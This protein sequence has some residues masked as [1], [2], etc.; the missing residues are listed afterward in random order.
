MNRHLPSIVLDSIFKLIADTEADQNDVRNPA[1]PD[2]YNFSLVNRCWNDEATRRLYRKI[3]VDARFL[4]CFALTDGTSL[5]TV[6]AM[7]HVRNVDLDVQCLRWTAIDKCAK[8]LTYC[9]HMDGIGINSMTLPILPKIAALNASSLCNLTY[10]EA[11]CLRCRDEPQRI[12]ASE[13]T[14]LAKCTPK[15]YWLDIAPRMYGFDIV[16]CEEVGLHHAVA[17]WALS[18]FM[19][20]GASECYDMWRALVTGKC[21]DTL[22]R[23]ELV[24]V[25]I[26]W[27]P[28][29]QDFVFTNLRELVFQNASL[30][31]PGE[32]VFGNQLQVLKVSHT[33]FQAVSADMVKAAAMSASTLRILHLNISLRTPA[34]QHP[35]FPFADLEVP[36][37]VELSAFEPLLSY[38]GLL[39]RPH[40]S[41]ATLEIKQKTTSM[42]TSLLIKTFPNV[43]SLLIASSIQEDV[44]RLVVSL[45]L[46]SNLRIASF[47]D[48]DGESFIGAV[49]SR[50]GM[51]PDAP[52]LTY[53]GCKRVVFAKS[54]LQAY[55]TQRSSGDTGLSDEAGGKGDVMGAAGHEYILCKTMGMLDVSPRYTGAI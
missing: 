44:F 18:D 10:I 21:R 31:K 51:Y 8:L 38:T 55:L 39:S 33:T 19:L 32:A 41:V 40:A 13:W 47:D 43:K 42:D 25:I 14:H 22:R 4:R 34:L 53:T 24:D 7:A 9:I 15:V 12:H 3:R 29:D 48:M 23:L 16:G 52:V 49:Q 20:S 37:L 11:N 17:V 36:T 1:L 28:A 2:L 30:P 50:T 27:K 54:L 26:D 45:P 5:N 35:A 46:L 6:K